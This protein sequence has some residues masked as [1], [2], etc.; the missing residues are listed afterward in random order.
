MRNWY[1]DFLIAYGE[2]KMRNA[3]ITEDMLALLFPQDLKMHREFLALYGPTAAYGLIA[4]II[5]YLKIRR[6]SKRALERIAHCLREELRLIKR[7]FYET[8][9]VD[10]L[11]TYRHRL[12]IA[13][14]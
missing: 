8:N 9:S 3:A 11:G 14:K 10:D 7:G 6:P 13:V 12:P 1:V 2:I 4:Y 5:H